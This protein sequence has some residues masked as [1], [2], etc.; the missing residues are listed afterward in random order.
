[1]KLWRKILLI[2]TALL[3]AGLI[4]YG[5]LPKPL[6]VEVVRIERGDLR[7]AVIEEGR[8]R[9]KD[10]YAISAPVAGYLSRIGLEAGST[11]RAGQSVAELGPAP[12]AMLDPRSREQAVA[13][14]SAA[15]AALSAASKN[16]ELSDAQD[17]YAE[18]QL[19][20]TKELFT[21]GYVSR[22]EYE[23]AETAARSARA[24][25][26][27]ARYSEEGARH[28]LSG[29][30]AA[31]NRISG[32]TRDKDIVRISSPV[33]G[34]VL[35]VLKK[36]EGMVQAGELI[37][38]VGNPNSIEVEVDVLSDDA[39]RISPGMKVLFERRDGYGQL[40]GVVRLIEPAGFTK[41][42]AL[43]VEEQRVW[44]ICDITSP[45]EKWRAL[46]H[47]YRME[48]AFI[49]SEGKGLLLAPEGALF[50]QAEGWAA[51][52]YDDGI[53]RMIT[54]KVGRRDG[55]RAE[56]LDGLKE[57]QLVI[58]YPDRSLKDGGRVKLR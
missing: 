1:M 21:S 38:E 35:K 45:Y 55:I 46:G 4:G 6:N 54:V 57:G 17:A 30:K 47:G 31:L 29:A 51:F 32:S 49:L 3:I 43:G 36:S 28:S 20:R 25:S 19:K 23:R 16:T 33:S 42:S 10:S 2:G 34:V 5:F 14:V 40:E 48:S 11:V 24:A 12:S 22:D 44:I 58:A 8:T 41:V 13:A 56:V 9:V 53:A 18:E 37:M 26:E 7:V 50:R 52:L 27:S 39:L 15:E